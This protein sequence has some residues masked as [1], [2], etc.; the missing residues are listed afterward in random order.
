MRLLNFSGIVLLFTFMGIQ[1][2][3]QDEEA[4]GEEELSN[5]QSYTP[6]KLLK[7]GQ[8]DVQLFNNLYTQTA[9]RD[10]DR[11]L[12]ELDQRSTYFAT[13][14]QVLFGTSKSA[15]VNWGVDVIFKSVRVD[16]DV[17]S[18][19][20]KVFN[21]ESS[22]LTRT[23]VT[24]IGPK[25]K[26][27]PFKNNPNFSIQSALW[28]PIASDLEADANAKPWLDWDRFT[29]WTQ[30][31]YSQQLGSK[32]QLFYEIDLLARF[33]KPASWYENNTA[34]SNF[35]STPASFFVNYFTTSKSTVYAMVQYAPNFEF[36][37]GTAIDS[38]YAQVGIGGKYQLT[39]HFAV[40]LLY[41]NFFT[42][43]NAGAGR[44]YNVGLRY[45][46]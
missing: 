6:S 11:D 36:N 1:V 39:S 25:I 4:S 13:F 7:K 8:V 46:K 20:I 34:K 23:A 16:N 14:T 42:A 32:F 35:L 33:S 41:S 38:D 10:M 15:R 37:G 28:I 17:K 40:E 12:V 19:A 44:T 43:K 3:A 30:F 9:F 26:F 29:S 22:N 45:I 18:A 5:I 27:S 2:Q 31:Y 21:F 24:A